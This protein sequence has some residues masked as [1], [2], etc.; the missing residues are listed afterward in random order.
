M[1]MIGIHRDRQVVSIGT[2]TKIFEIELVAIERK[3][4]RQAVE[5]YDIAPTGTHWSK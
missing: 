5:V 4:G 2:K 1:T 3:D